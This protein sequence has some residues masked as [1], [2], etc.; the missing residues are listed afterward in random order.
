MGIEQT[1]QFTLS[2]LPLDENAIDINKASDGLL[3]ELYSEEGWI[4]KYSLE[5]SS[6]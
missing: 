1:D 2:P 3:G 4:K 6:E 5:Q